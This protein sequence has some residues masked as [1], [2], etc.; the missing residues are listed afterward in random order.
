M[1]R[2]TVFTMSAVACVSLS[3][4][5]HMRAFC[6]NEQF[7]ILDWAIFSCKVKGVFKE[8]CNQVLAKVR[9]R[10]CSISDSRCHLRG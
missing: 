6:F 3:D 2:G 4:G 1:Q 8:L 7:I 5:V 9:Y 10:F